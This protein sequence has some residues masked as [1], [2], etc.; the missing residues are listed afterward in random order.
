MRLLPVSLITLP[1]YGIIVTMTKVSVTIIHKKLG[2]FILVGFTK[3]DHINPTRHLAYRN[4]HKMLGRFILVVFSKMD[5]IYLNRLLVYNN[6]LVSSNQNLVFVRM[7][8]I[9]HPTSNLVVLQ[10]LTARKTHSQTLPCGGIMELTM[11]V[12]SFPLKT[13]QGEPDRGLLVSQT[14]TIYHYATQA[15]Q[16]VVL[17]T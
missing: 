15:T 11:G 3:M 14:W 10:F 17:V 1:L 5:H 4:L 6:L 16:A 13:L 8:H 9:L 2:K 7:D 12:H